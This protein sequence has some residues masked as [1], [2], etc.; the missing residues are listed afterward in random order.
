[1]YTPKLHFNF[2][3][4]IS[5]IEKETKLT[6]LAPILNQLNIEGSTQLDELMNVFFSDFLITTK[7][8]NF[9]SNVLLTLW[10]H[11]KNALN[12]YEITPLNLEFFFKKFSN[13]IFTKLSVKENSYF[14]KKNLYFIFSIF[15]TF[16]TKYSSDFNFLLDLNN[17]KFFQKSYLGHH[18][19]Y[20]AR[21]KMLGRKTNFRYKIKKKKFEDY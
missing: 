15:Y 7:L 21:K 14:K 2:L 6:K 18:Y 1:M 12:Y 19:T 16:S 20:S 10:K 8:R 13:K 5:I 17:Y 3:L 4:K 11:N 9:S